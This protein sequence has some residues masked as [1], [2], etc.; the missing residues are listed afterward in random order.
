MKTILLTGASGFT[1]QHLIK[2]AN[3]LGYNIVALCHKE[4]E[5]VK[6]CS[7]IIVADLGDKPT[8]KREL[9]RIKPDFVIHLA[10]ISFVA[11]GNVK[12]IYSTNL[13]GTVNL[14]DCL[15]E[16]SFPIQ[17]VL[18]ASSGNVYGNNSQLPISENMLP[19]PV[20]DYAVSKYAMEL[21]VQL[22]FSE[23]PIILVRPFNYTGYGQAEHFL[24]PKIVHAFKQ[25][26]KTIELG[27]LDVARD[28]SDVRDVVA[29]Y[30]KLLESNVHS[31]VF[32]ICTGKA[33]SL[34]CVVEMLDVLAG[35]KIDVSVNPEFVREN[36]IKELYGNNQKLVDVIGEYQNYQFADTLQWMYQHG[37]SS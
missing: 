13:I 29:A 12:D 37:V 17:K 24:I 26:N 6:G 28:F 16:L 27:N 2:H 1:G 22:R 31:E 30:T 36:E 25:N 35:Y 8:L 33:I 20:N 4:K 14:L 7:E 34:L 21:A 10:A 15:I 9:A 3:S 32:N 5:Y 18:I 23:L 11:H 19:S